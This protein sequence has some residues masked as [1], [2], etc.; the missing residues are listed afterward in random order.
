MLWQLLNLIPTDD[1][2][3]AISY[4]R[5]DDTVGRICV[6]FDVG[7][8]SGGDASFGSYLYDITGAFRT[9][10]SSDGTAVD[11]DDLAT[12]TE[13]NNQN[14]VGMYY[15]FQAPGDINPHTQFRAHRTAAGI[16]FE[17][18]SED[19][20]GP[21]FDPTPDSPQTRIGHNL[22]VDSGGK[23]STLYWIALY[24][25]LLTQQ[26]I[27]D[28]TSGKK[29]PVDDFTPVLY[30][31]FHKAVGA[32][33]TPDVGTDYVYGVEGSPALI[34][35]GESSL[36]TDYPP[37]VVTATLTTA[38]NIR[39]LFDS[40]MENN[41]ALN[42]VTN[43]VFS[44]GLSAVAITVVDYCTL[45]LT[46]SGNPVS[47][48]ALT[49]SNVEDIL[50]T[51]IFGTTAPLLGVTP[52][53]HLNPSIL[54]FN[55]TLT[56]D[57]PQTQ[58][59][60]V[61][62]VGAVTLDPITVSGGADWLT[63]WLG[64]SGNTQQIMN[65]VDIEGLPLGVYSTT[66]TVLC[67][68]ASNSPITY[69]VTLT[70]SAHANPTSLQPNIIIWVAK[71]GNDSTGTGSQ[72]NPYFTIERALQEFVN[73][74]QIRILNGTYT[75]AD[76]IVINGL[77]GSIF[78]ET[79]GGAVIQPQRTTQYGAGI[80]IINSNR[81][82]VQGVHIKQS[83]ETQTATSVAN[84]IGLYATNIQ[85]FVAHTVTVSDFVCPSGCAG[86]WAIGS[87]RIEQCLIEDLTSD[88]GDLYGIYANGI[89]VSD[90]TVRRLSNK[91]ND[92]L[93]GI[94]TVSDYVI[95]P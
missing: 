63:V 28:L 38:T 2:T 6:P 82:T 10:V 55:A 91:G 44:G 87:G 79:P 54:T 78:S 66:V 15:D 70:I 94:Y 89:L 53:L 60:D 86:I 27:E 39:V 41:A 42:L 11:F 43:Y 1:F 13:L 23:S 35:L 65:R 49:V 74:S 58:T 26:D 50:G 68:N 75:P 52:T 72:Q 21:I 88:N 4:T 19:Y 57:A 51:Q 85:N 3:F 76:T 31:D 92:A 64:G 45:D 5:Q 62:N 14:I 77:E 22:G 47:G 59:I 67:S 18:A 36:R 9:Y 73:G 95:V 83:T 61:T 20:P 16:A 48:E 34:G 71:T 32:T 84:T 24:H 80:A 69:L 37:S 25:T 7:S 93:L 90:S 56:H 81:F 17:S 46:V 40:P 33:Y 12:A 29:H 8:W 30:L